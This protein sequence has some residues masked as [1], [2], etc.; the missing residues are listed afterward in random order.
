MKNPRLNLKIFKIYVI[1]MQHAS[2]ILASFLPVRSAQRNFKFYKAL[3]AKFYS[4]RERYGAKSELRERA[5]NFGAINIRDRFERFLKFQRRGTDLFDL[6]PKK[7][8]LKF[9]SLGSS[10]AKFCPLNLIPW[11]K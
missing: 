7:F 2:A 11:R 4:W 6:A 10:R 9:H 1:R 3:S 5:V 8:A